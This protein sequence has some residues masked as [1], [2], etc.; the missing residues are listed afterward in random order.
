MPGGQPLPRRRR[1][2]C[3]VDDPGR[4][5]VFQD[6]PPCRDRP[7][8]PV[9]GPVGQAEAAAAHRGGQFL[10]R[11]E[12][13][14]G[15]DPGLAVHPGGL[16]QVVVRWHRRASSRRWKPYMG[17]TPFRAESQARNGLLPVQTQRPV[18]LPTSKSHDRRK[19]R[20]AEG[21]FGIS[22]DEEDLRR[23]W[24]RHRCC[25]F[26]MTCRHRGRPGQPTC[27]LGVA[28]HNGAQ[29]CEDRRHTGPPG[30]PTLGSIRLAKSAGAPSE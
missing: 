20:L 22:L 18:T 1:P 25:R 16:H 17:N 2:G 29:R 3:L 12:V 23:P 13:L 9:Q 4:A 27:P 19:V 7:E 14:L 11:P 5:E 30:S 10:R 8:V 15:D 24:P 6:S 28:L 21:D 26:W